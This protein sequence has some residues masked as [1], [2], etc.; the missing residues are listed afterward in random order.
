MITTANKEYMFLHCNIISA[1]FT[2]KGFMTCTG[3]IDKG[4]IVVENGNIKPCQILMLPVDVGILG[5]DPGGY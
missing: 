4:R 2:M 3:A 5:S 1:A